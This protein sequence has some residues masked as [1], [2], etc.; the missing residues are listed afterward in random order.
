MSAQND[1]F[2][3]TELLQGELVRVYVFLRS[4]SATFT[5]FQRKLSFQRFGSGG[6][7]TTIRARFDLSRSDPIGFYWNIAPIRLD[8]RRSIVQW[9]N[10]LACTE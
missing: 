3:P 6:N 9:N 7:N 2:C 10:K 8:L 5:A 1:V 4:V